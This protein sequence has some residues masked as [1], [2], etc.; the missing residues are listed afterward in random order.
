MAIDL[1]HVDICAFFDVLCSFETK[2][3]SLVYSV[4][5]CLQFSPNLAR[6]GSN[7]LRNWPEEF[8]IALR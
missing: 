7:Q 3:A 5:S 1:H 8:V 2:L 6:L 4:P